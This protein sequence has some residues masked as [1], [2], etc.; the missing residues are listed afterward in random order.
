MIAWQELESTIRGTK[1][2]GRGKHMPTFTIYL[3][4]APEGTWV[5]L[6]CD[7]ASCS[8]ATNA[9]PPGSLTFQF[10]TNPAA[11]PFSSFCRYEFYLIETPGWCGTTLSSHLPTKAFNSL[12]AQS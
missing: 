11:R 7:I 8:L 9:S 12:G 6:R 5:M 4:D 1:M 2:V 10:G 3:A